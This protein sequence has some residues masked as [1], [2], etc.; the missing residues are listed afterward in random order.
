[1]YFT[2]LVYSNIVIPVSEFFVKCQLVPLSRLHRHR[3]RTCT[4][5]LDARVVRFFAPRKDF[6]PPLCVLRQSEWSFLQ[7]GD[8]FVRL[9]F[10][11]GSPTEFSREVS[12]APAEGVILRNSRF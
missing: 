1:M 10:F 9:R 4:Y 3:V 11:V 2:E 7:K 5:R 6:Q 12:G 8:N